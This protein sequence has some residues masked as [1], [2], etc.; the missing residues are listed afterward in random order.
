MEI[1]S[2]G[3]EKYELSTDLK[4]I[5]F[6]CVHGWLAGSYWSPGIAREKVERAAKGSSL[7]IGIYLRETGQQVAY[8]RVVS[9]RAT[10]AWIA[11]IFVD[12]DHRGKGLA[13][14]MVRYA[15]SHPEHQGLRRWVLATKDA[16]D[17]YAACGF[18]PLPTPE[19]WMAYPPS[20]PPA[21]R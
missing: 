19:R 1:K 17:I 21:G 6:E 9:D 2:A 11:D 3:D 14:R 16:H 13:K 7:V 10:F 12:P 5:D 20:S 8:G 4:R 15:L 18:E